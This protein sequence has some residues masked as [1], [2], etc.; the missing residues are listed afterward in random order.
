MKPLSDLFI[1]KIDASNLEVHQKRLMQTFLSSAMVLSLGAAVV[2]PNQSKHQLGALLGI[3]SFLGLLSAQCAESRKELELRYESY[4]NMNREIDKQETAGV[5]THRV[6]WLRVL[7]E[8]KLAADIR[9][10]PSSAQERYAQM[11]QLQGLGIGAVAA[12]KAPLVEYSGEPQVLTEAD[13]TRQLEVIQEETGFD[14][15]WIDAEFVNKS[16]AII[17]AKKSGKTYFMHHLASRWKQNN[18]EGIIIIFDSHYDP[19]TEEGTWFHG[20]EQKPLLDTVIFKKQEHIRDKFKEI[21]KE[22]HRRIENDLK[23]PHVPR[24]HIFWDEQDSYFKYWTTGL[25]NDPRVFEETISTVATI[26]DECRKYG[27]DI[28]IGMHSI[29]KLNT[30]ID[31]S[32]L[33][34]MT[35]VMFEKACMA[36]NSVFP[37]DFAVSAI[38][39]PMLQ[40]MEEL[41]RSKGRAVIVLDPERCKPIIT[42]LPL[43]PIIQLN[44]QGSETPKTSPEDIEIYKQLIEYCREVLNQGEDLPT[45]EEIQELYNEA[46]ERE[47]DKKIA[48]MILEQGQKPPQDKEGE[49]E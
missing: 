9:Q 44:V 16:K 45:V 22:I 46:T 29:K 19:S 34:Q 40:L 39:P 14:T 24:I 18:P 23:P 30:G 35:W 20:V 33:A 38:R 6:K 17:G 1:D 47:L 42:G 2:A 36:A 48:E 13:L 5:F 21:Q 43:L 32:T 4:L 31:S 11:F 8:L 37:G 49:K 25:G 41:D 28:T 15:S 12:P 10:L 3:S 26:Q 7:K 27:I